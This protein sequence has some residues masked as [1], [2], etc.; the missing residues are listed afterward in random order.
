MNNKVLQDVFTLRMCIGF[1][2]E[3]DQYSW[4]PSAFLSSTS[5]AFLSPVFGKTSF[6]AQ[7]YGVREAAAIVH[8]EHIGIGKGVFHLFRL[9]ENH[10]IEMHRLL[11]NQD[12]K[13]AVKDLIKNKESAETFLFEYGKE[14]VD[15]TVGP[16]RLGEITNILIPQTWAKASGQYARAFQNGYKIFPYFLTS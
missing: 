7:Y 14:A 11:D 5:S 12:T 2:G 6:N 8:D 13:R 1:L 10:E 9:P 15:Q 3:S 16:F 4:W